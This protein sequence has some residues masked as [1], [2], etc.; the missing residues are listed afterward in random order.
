[1]PSSWGSSSC[2]T[3]QKS[4]WCSLFLPIK[5]D[6]RVASVVMSRKASIKGADTALDRLFQPLVS[7][8]VVLESFEIILFDMR[9]LS[10]P[11][12][13]GRVRPPI[14]RRP[15]S[16]HAVELLERD[17]GG[18]WGSRPTSVSVA[19]CEVSIALA[20]PPSGAPTWIR[21][22]GVVG[23]SGGRVRLFSKN[24]YAFSFAAHH[25]AVVAAHVLS[26]NEMERLEEN[27]FARVVVITCGEDGSAYVWRSQV[28]KSGS[29]PCTSL[30]MKPEKISG[31]SS[32]LCRSSAFSFL[33][34]SCRCPGTEGEHW[35]GPR[36]LLFYAT[37]G[38]LVAQPLLSASDT[39]STPSTMRLPV[40]ESA[41]PSN[42]RRWAN[43]F[44]PLTSC[45]PTSA[46]ATAVLAVAVHPSGF[47]VLVSTSDRFLIRFQCPS[48]RSSPKILLRLEKR[49]NSISFGGGAPHS[50]CGGELVALS[51]LEDS[52]VWVV[53]PQY[54]QAVVLGTFFGYQNEP[55]KQVVLYEQLGLLTLVGVSGEAELVRLPAHCYTEAR[56]GGGGAAEMS[57]SVQPLIAALPSLRLLRNRLLLE[58]ASQ[59]ELSAPE[60]RSHPSRPRFPPA[61]S[62]DRPSSPLSLVFATKIK[63]SPLWKP[64]KSRE[65]IRAV[66][67]ESA[68]PAPTATTPCVAPRVSLRRRKEALLMSFLLQPLRHAEMDTAAPLCEPSS[69]TPPPQREDVAH[70]L[71][72][73][74][75]FIGHQAAS[76]S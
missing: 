2:V 26:A 14:L 25:C 1:M 51:A 53:R 63:A 71:E 16:S 40:A 8:L 35:I 50:G 54:P 46:R 45:L 30:T 9:D 3:N 49:V 42:S 74:A 7:L 33:Y 57:W 47:F 20:N 13:E 39:L 17:E 34:T 61:A 76:S 67:G 73:T 36:A 31:E 12:E 69:D 52:V 11:A 32:V 65:K 72:E 62:R 58:E 66:E 55:L 19:P 44:R 28:V 10:G 6:E 21:L 68:P 41:K 24:D 56:G 27:R 70:H 15:A 64:F 22:L 59:R 37:E 18:D 75:E 43:A 5:K 38:A 4:K 48:N 60:P 29:P 23:D